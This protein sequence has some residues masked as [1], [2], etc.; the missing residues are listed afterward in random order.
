MTDGYAAGVARARGG[1]LWGSPM[2]ETGLRGSPALRVQVLE[3]ARLPRVESARA[4]LICP[5]RDRSEE[6]AGKRQEITLSVSVE[7]RSFWTGRS[8][9]NIPLGFAGHAG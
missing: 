5:R 6:M 2:G 9:E 4:S 8:G 1:G 3:I 7:Q